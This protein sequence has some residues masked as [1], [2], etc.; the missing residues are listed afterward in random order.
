[1]SQWLTQLDV[2]E[3]C[4]RRGLEV[5]QALWD[6]LFG[7]LREAGYNI[8]SLRGEGCRTFQKLWKG[9]G[10]GG[11]RPDPDGEPRLLIDVIVAAQQL[12]LCRMRRA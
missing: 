4:W 12:T 9:D 5:R 3:F 2:Q 7:I 10:L 6:A 11:G 1:M 8:R